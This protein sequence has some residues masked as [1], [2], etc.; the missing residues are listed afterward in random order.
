MKKETRL[1]S[2]KTKDIFTTDDPLILVMEFKN[3]LLNPDATKEAKF[4]KKGLYN[5]QISTKIF[6]LLDKNGVPNHFVKTLD[7]RSMA[8]KRLKMIPIKVVIRRKAA[9]AMSESLGLKEGAK[10]NCPVLDLYLKNDKLNTPRLTEDYIKALDITSE[11]IM[12]EIKELSWKTLDLLANFFES[13]G[14]DL[15]DCKLE[16]GTDENGNVILGDEISPDNCRLWQLKTG[17]ILDKDRLQKDL[18]K[19]EES[20][21]EV[22]DRVMQAK[23]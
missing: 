18:G 19:I 7:E 4:D 22:W 21:H 10:L 3:T 14:I 20:Y 13:I 6:K 12:A 17:E 5:N 8:V 16:F 9:G 1:Y 15:I 11:S 23:S 2:G